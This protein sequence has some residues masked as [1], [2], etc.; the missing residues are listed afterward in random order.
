LLMEDSQLIWEKDEKDCITYK[1]L[2]KLL[3]VG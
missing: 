2:V 1:R 3:V